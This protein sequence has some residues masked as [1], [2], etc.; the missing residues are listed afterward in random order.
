MSL[1]NENQYR[2]QTHLQTVAAVSLLAVIGF[3]HVAYNK[4][5]SARLVIAEIERTH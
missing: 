5:S 4:S 1:P 3:Q 2:A